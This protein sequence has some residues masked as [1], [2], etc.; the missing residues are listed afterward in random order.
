MSQKIVSKI[1]KL[2]VQFRMYG[3]NAREWMRKCVMMLPEIE[4]ERVWEK[5]GFGSI[6]DYAGR[7]TGMSH[8]VVN[9]GLR[10]LHAVEHMPDIVYVIKKRGIGIIRPIVTLLTMDNQK[11]WAEKAMIMSKHT[12]EMY[13]H[14]MKKE[15]KEEQNMAA[16]SMFGTTELD[17]RSL[18]ETLLGLTQGETLL[19]LTGEAEIADL[20]HKEAIET[21]NITNNIPRDGELQEC[22]TSQKIFAIEL[23]SELIH[24]LEKLKGEHGNYNDVIRNLLEM[25][26]TVLVQ[27]QQRI[28]EEVPGATNAKSRHIPAEIERFIIE[29][30]GGT[31]EYP[32]CMRKYEIIHHTQRFAIEQI[33]DPEK[34][35]ALCTQHERLAHLGLIMNEE[36]NSKHWTLKNN[37]DISSQ[38]FKIDQLVQKYR[39]P[40]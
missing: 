29:R 14:E 26:Q 28:Q 38:K 12:L 21:E 6:H 23:E 11:F 5:K 2:H 4:R 35:T 17:T 22:K 7:L 9:E 15:M 16:R 31:C 10:I 13:V 36:Q 32:K 19:G 27:E 30:S 20:P 37:P 1:Q 3:K 40:K 34:M 33:H 25:R 18:G 24:Q 8:D 39:T